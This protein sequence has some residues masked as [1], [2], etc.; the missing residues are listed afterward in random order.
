MDIREIR[1][2]NLAALKREIGTLRALADQAPTDPNYLSQILGGKGNVGHQLARKLEKAAKKPV[3]WMDQEHPLPAQAEESIR[4]I[5]RY[6]RLLP[7]V[8]IKAVESLL[9]SLVVNKDQP[10]SQVRIQLAG[11]PRAP[12]PSRLLQHDHA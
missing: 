6:A 1:R 3:G 9:Q 10:D 12:K 7:I 8:Q 11:L 2:E 4:N 5:N